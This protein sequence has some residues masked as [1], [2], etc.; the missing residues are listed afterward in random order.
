MTVEQY[1]SWLEIAMQN[2]VLMRVLDSMRHLGHKPDAFAQFV[3]QDR[4]G[5]LQA[6]SSR[7]LHAEEGQAVFA[8][9]DFIN[10]KDIRM[11]ETGRRFSFTPE[12]FQRFARI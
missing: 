9:A 8:M 4:P 7:V 11:I 10:G 3:A 5:F 12:T 1:V 2:A 6:A